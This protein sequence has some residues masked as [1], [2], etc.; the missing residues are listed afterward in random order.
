MIGILNYLTTKLLN[1]NR[2]AILHHNRL[3]LITDLPYHI[4]ANLLLTLEVIELNYLFS[5]IGSLFL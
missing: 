4:M 3:N 2:L 5:G 1:L